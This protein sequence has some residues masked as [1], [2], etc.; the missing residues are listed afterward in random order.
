MK[1][2]LSRPYGDPGF[3]TPDV[4]M[5]AVC[6]IAEECGF[7]WVTYGHHT[8]RP[9]DEP[10]QPPHYGVPYYQDPLI[11]A[12]RAL[13][14]TKTLEVSTGVLIMPMLHPVNVA[15]Q[16][17]TLD[18]YSGGR[19]ALGVGT[20]GASRL[21]IE[22]TGG[23]GRF[24]RRWAYTMESIQIMKGLWTEDRFEFKGEFFDIPPVCMAPRP[25]RKPH[26]P[27]WLGGY[28]DGLLTRI[29]QHCNGWVPAYDG[30]DI[31]PFLG[32]DMSGP[33]HVRRGKARLAEL[34]EGFGRGGEHFEVGVIVS[35]GSDPDCARHYED[36][37]ADRFALSLPEI[38]TIDDARR[39]IETFATQLKL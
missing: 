20:G 29:A 25:A 35:P 34:A 16:V 6:Q 26:T 7:H 33:E 23:P 9:L 27:V 10:V 37:G 13:A 14:M 4:D 19:F 24:E 15:K 2:G 17:A 12:A 38:E 22:V 18:C 21:E 1:Y 39:A 28:T 11:G 31:Y 36:A 30:L 8:V 32:I 5:G 3:P